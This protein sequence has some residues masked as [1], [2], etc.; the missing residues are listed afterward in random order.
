MEPGESSILTH[1]RRGAL[2]HCVLAMLDP[3]PRYGL[4]IAR[5]LG[6]LKLLRYLTR[7]LTLSEALE[8]L[9]ANIEVD[10]RYVA[11]PSG[12]AAIDVDTPDDLD[13]VRT[14]AE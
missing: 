13:L 6:L 7:R 12:R 9:G 2:E 5:R 10:A 3:T 4:D 1:L 11:A 8:A 14:L